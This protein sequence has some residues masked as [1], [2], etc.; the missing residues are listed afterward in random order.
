MCVD[1]PDSGGA[2]LV[3]EEL[4]IVGVLGVLA[5]H[6]HQRYPGLPVAVLQVTA[7]VA[8]FIHSF[9]LF[10]VKQREVIKQ[11]KTQNLWIGVHRMSLVKIIFQ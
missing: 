10:F 8:S 6:P 9:H 11:T 4:V 1:S 3:R 2:L 5:M 7:Q